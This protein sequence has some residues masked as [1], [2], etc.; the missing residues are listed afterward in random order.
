M[1]IFVT[2]REKHKFQEKLNHLM[3]IFINSVYLNMQVFIR[4]FISRS[5]PTTPPKGARR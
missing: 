5:S 4:K 3:D 1:R 2:I